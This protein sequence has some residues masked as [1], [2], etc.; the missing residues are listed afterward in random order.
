MRP[1]HYGAC[2]CV[3]PALV[4]PW[5]DSTQ[6]G[7]GANTAVCSRSLLSNLREL[8][9]DGVAVSLP[10]LQ[11]V[12]MRLRELNVRGSCLQGSA[13]GFFTRGW[14]ALST[15]SL[16]DARVETATVTAALQ[17][18]ALENLNIDGFRHQGGVLQLDQLA[19]SCPNIKG[20]RLQL[21]DDLAWGRQGGGPCCSLL[22][23]GRLEDLY[24]VIFIR[25][26]PPCADLGF[27]LPA[28]LT[29]FEVQGASGGEWV[30]D[31]FWFLSEAVKCIRR[32][33]PLRKLTCTYTEAYLQ[34]PQ[35]GATLNEQYRRL[36]GQLSS[37]REL[38]VSGDTEK[39]LSALCAVASS[40]PHIAC[41][42]FTTGE[43]L[44]LLEELP[45]IHSASLESITFIVDEPS[46][47]SH[48]LPRPPP[49]LTFLHGC[50]R[51]QRVLLRLPKA[52]RT[53]GTAA[54]IRCHSG[55]QACVVPID[56]HARAAECRR[57]LGYVGNFNEVCVEIL[58]GPPS[59]Q[60]VQSYT[61]LYTCHAAGPQQPL[62]WGHAVVPGFV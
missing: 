55:S 58:P 37:L 42:K 57:V 4:V 9:L 36:G 52:Y 11:P 3:A 38:E 51:L 15:L 17:L 22:D 6:D 60:G 24:M 7:P 29:Q 2:M 28:S 43:W 47:L 33:A 31:L 61:V 21:E 26:I 10:A 46:W 20:L 59:P 5:Q 32:G 30:L 14:T 50:T 13:D 12:A 27:D 19:G 49:V 18:P 40:A 56:V 44:P 35:W 25:S 23:L 54:K 41:V 45:P 53:E 34:P 8:T 62:V 16:Q 39:V 48:G 1:S